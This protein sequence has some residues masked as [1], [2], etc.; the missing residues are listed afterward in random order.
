[1][2]IVNSIAYIVYSSDIKHKYMSEK[3]G[4]LEER[5]EVS[6]GQVGYQNP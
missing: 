3:C 6:S 1:M 2:N 5:K 4:T